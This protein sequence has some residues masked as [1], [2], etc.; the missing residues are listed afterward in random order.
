M[1]P[2]FKVI[3]IDNLQKLLNLLPNFP[4]YQPWQHWGGADLPP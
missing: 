4:D 1:N 3:C 2:I